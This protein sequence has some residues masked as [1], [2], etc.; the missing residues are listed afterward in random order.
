MKGSGAVLTAVGM[1]T[2]INAVSV[3]RRRGAKDAFGVI[4][5]GV[6]MFVT[7]SALGQLYDWR[8]ARAF[9]LLLLLGTFLMRGEDTA[10]WFEAA[11]GSFTNGK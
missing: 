11:A 2:V 7:L 10:N 1:A 6:A 3:T 8:V 9:A 4:F 5:G